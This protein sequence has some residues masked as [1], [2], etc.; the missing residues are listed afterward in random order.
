M[1]NLQRSLHNVTN[2][3]AG[4]PYLGC[5]EQA[6]QLLDRLDNLELDD[7]WSFQRVDRLWPLP[8]SWVEG[9]S[10]N[11]DDPHVTVDPWNDYV[12]IQHYKG[13]Y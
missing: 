4:E 6:D 9:E 2:G 10:D 1:N 5:W 3:Y 11:P 7:S 12:I 13:H 8:H